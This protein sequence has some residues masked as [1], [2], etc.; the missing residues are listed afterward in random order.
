[1][2]EDLPLVASTVKGRTRAA[3]TRELLEATG[4][5][6]GPH[7]HRTGIGL[8]R[9]RGHRWLHPRRAGVRQRRVRAPGRLHRQSG[10]PPHL[11]LRARHRPG[12]GHA[13]HRRARGGP[14]L[15]PSGTRNGDDSPHP[16]TH[17]RGGRAPGREPVGVQAGPP[18]LGSVQPSTAVH[19][20]DDLPVRPALRARYLQVHRSVRW[21]R[22]STGGGHR[23]HRCLVPTPRWW[24]VR[25]VPAKVLVPSCTAP[26]Q[27]E[28]RHDDRHARAH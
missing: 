21:L 1:M 20:G 24:A 9:R 5:R 26:T 8:L 3:M 2:T 6:S 23:R 19:G 15:A 25:A 27:K 13:G 17:R 18:W 28:E 7:G 14:G 22:H 4:R 11:Q 16:R 10:A 12:P